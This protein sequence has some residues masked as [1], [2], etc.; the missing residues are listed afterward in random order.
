MSILGNFNFK[1]L[2]EGLSK[3]RDNIFNKI[4]ETFSGKAYVDEETIDELEEILLTS[5][6]GVEIVEEI[7]ETTRKNF[8]IKKDRSKESLLD[9]LKI[10]LTNFIQSNDNINILSKDIISEH[11]PYVILIVGVNGVGKTTTIGKLAY[12]LKFE[13]YSVIL[14]AADTFRAAAGEQ[15]DLWAKRAGVE[16]HTKISGSDPSSVAFETI[17]IAIKKNIDIVIIDTAGRLHT[18]NNLMNELGKIN[19]VL[20]KKLDYAPNQTLLV[21]DGNTG[22]NAINQAKEFSKFVNITGL[23]VTKLDGTA[24]GGVMFSIKKL[25]NI[26]ILYIGVGEGIEDLQNFVPNAFVNALFE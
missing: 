6:M 4:N 7:I 23:I 19:K 13:G 20:S 17:E 11:K 9:E 3:T 10:S 16:I 24:K 18:K 22:Q 12:N 2:K 5:D 14:G 1:K 26:P 8:K 21:V 25:L 15:L